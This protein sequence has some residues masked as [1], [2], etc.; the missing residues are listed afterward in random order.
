MKSRHTP[1]SIMPNPEKQRICRQ[2]SLKN[3]IL[4][5]CSDQEKDFI[6]LYSHKALAFKVDS[7]NNQLHA[8]N[9]STV[10]SLNMYYLF[11]HPAITLNLVFLSQKL[12]CT[13]TWVG[14]I[15]TYGPC[16][17]VIYSGTFL[18][19][20]GREGIKVVHVTPR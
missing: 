12:A 5:C 14:T 8:S 4:N 18:K 13:H 6:Q 3:L 10:S 2:F 15:Q 1:L 20:G 9:H 19:Q 11:K 7:L 17:Q 16:K